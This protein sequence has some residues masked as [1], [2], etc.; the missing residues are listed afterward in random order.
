MQITLQLLTLLGSLALFLY[1]MTLMS[2]GLQKAAGDKLRSFLAAM[3]STPFKRV[4]TGLTITALIQS[5][6]GT[7]VMVVGMVNAGLLSLGNAIGVI[8]GANIGTTVTAWLITLFGFSVDI[9]KV[10]VPFIALG[11]AFSISKKSKSKNIGQVIIG[12]ALLILGLA[13]LKESVPDLNQ[14][15]DALAFVQFLTNYHFGSVLIFLAIGTILTI[16]LQASSATMAL[17]MVF[18]SNGWIGFD[19]AAAMVLGENI[20]TTITANIAASVANRSA[21]RAAL[22]HTVFNVFG[23][24]W[25]LAL[26]RPFLRTIGGAVSLMG[27]P[28]PTGVDLTGIDT[29][30]SI[31]N[32]VLYGVCTLHTLFNVTNTLLLIWFV[33]LIERLVT[34]MVPNKNEEIFRLKFIQGGP[35]STAELSLDMAR[36]EIVHF[37]EICKKDFQYVR[38]AVNADDTSVFAQFR[39]K[40]VKYEAITDKVEYEIVSYLNGVAAGE[41]SRASAIRMNGMYKMVGEL[42]SVGD[43]GESIGRMLQRTIDYEKKLG[44]GMLKNINR[45]LDLLDNAFDV[46]IANLRL[47]FDTALD[48]SGAEAAENHLNEYRNTL[49]EEHIANIED[50]KDYDYQQGVF[51]M[52]IVAEI[53]KAG[54]FIINVSQAQIADKYGS[55]A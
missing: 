12:F 10:A 51:Y 19:M 9:S 36:Q 52:D 11:M 33:P 46:M 13:A 26:F 17:T 32:S 44:P 24:L 29:D 1:G 8:M 53:E 41:I 49:R 45:M 54:D 34:M 25:V 28:D 14:H 21:K 18:V 4:V 30:M 23:V 5:S 50:N 42:E 38:N 3:T 43:S 37:A 40:L 35:L 7:T 20:G 31:K 39:E 22:A 47:P 6:S 2:E 15:P 48:L 27:L 55:A 16:V